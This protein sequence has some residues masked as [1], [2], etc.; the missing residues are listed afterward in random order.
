V[1]SDKKV[2]VVGSY[3]ANSET[4]AFVALL[5][6][7]EN[8]EWL[9]TFDKKEGKSHGILIDHSD[10]YLAVV[11]SV[12]NENDVNNYL[13]LLDVN[14]NEKKNIK[15]A[16]N[17]V[18]RKLIYDDINETFFIAFKGN[19][20]SPYDVSDD[21]LQL[22]SLNSSLT[23]V[24]N[25]SLQFTGYLSNVIRTNNQLYIYGAYS[26]LKDAA[27]KVYTTDNKKINLFA[28]T[29]DALANQVSLKTFDA[30][31]SYYPLIVSKISNE[32]I[33]VINVKNKIEANNDKRSSY[34]LI[35]SSSNEVYYKSE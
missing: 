11:I 18:P 31:F 24:W 27:G 30:P 7:S 29:I 33:D 17:A 34:Y 4:Q 3:A 20:Y 10:N 14:G 1:T 12:D 6:D 8:I 15:L 19:L 21:A 22:Y 13:Y 35:I 9:K 16:S 28:Y 5:S 25:S 23:P 32:Y 2:F 26:E